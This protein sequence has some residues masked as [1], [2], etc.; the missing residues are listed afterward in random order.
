MFD[1]KKNLYVVLQIVGLVLLFFY[2]YGTLV[3]IIIFFYGG[4][5][6]RTEIYNPKN[7]DKWDY[8]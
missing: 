7:K 1:I 6:Y 3:G 2:P 5:K 4:Y 8:Y